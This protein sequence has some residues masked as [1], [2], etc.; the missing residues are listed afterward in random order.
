[1]EEDNG[2]DPQKEFTT[3]R[4]IP[5]LTKLAT[6]A[7][8]VI[9]DML[10]LITDYYATDESPEP[11][12]SQYISNHHRQVVLGDMLDTEVSKTFV[13]VVPKSENTRY[14]ILATLKVMID[15]YDLLA[16]ESVY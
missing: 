15:R 5:L 8:D 4:G 12:H 7:T 6:Q 9:S 1:M 11:R 13:E 16:I 3:L 2:S 14:T 10:D